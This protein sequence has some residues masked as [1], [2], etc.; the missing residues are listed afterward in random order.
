MAQEVVAA[1]PDKT[2]RADATTAT[3]VAA[4]VVLQQEP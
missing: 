1:N 4:E 2:V 3:A